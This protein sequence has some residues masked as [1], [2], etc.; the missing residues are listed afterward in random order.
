MPWTGTGANPPLYPVAT[1]SGW[2]HIVIPK[3]AINGGSDANWADIRRLLLTVYDGN[4]TTAQTLLLGFANIR[5]TGGPGGGTPPSITTQPANQTVTVGQTATFSVV[6]AGSTPLS[7]QWRK[8]GVN[9]SG[10]TSSSYTTPP[11][12]S[13]DN[14]ALFSVVVN[15]AFGS[16]TSANATLTV[17]GGGGGLPSPWQTADI[18]AVGSAGSASYS[19]G[20][21]TVVGSGVDIQGTAD[22]FRYVYQTAT[23]NCEIKAR[24]TGVGNTDPW[25]KAGV[26]IR[27]T[28]TAGSK[29]AVMSVT[30][31]S[32]VEFLYR[33]RTGGS[34]GQ[35]LSSGSA[36]LWIRVVRSNKNF[37]GYTSPDGVT[38]TTIGSI[39]IN[40][41]SSVYIGLSVTSH[42]D[43]TLNT[44]TFDNVTATP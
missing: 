38:W 5:F 30:P 27:E 18:G 37:T 28:L 12:V 41:S 10:A 21:F 31:S 25:A 3:S 44:S 6:A 29:H 40:M 2:Q 35:A 19:T 32:G 7:Y 36:P 24:V 14:G 9:I 8:N 23:G 16:V 13:G 22:E 17:T 43:G 33:T 11:T 4:Y 20:T 42:A 1:N 39:N 34:S 15:N 26:M